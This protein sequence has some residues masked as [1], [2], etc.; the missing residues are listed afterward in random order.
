MTLTD[1]IYSPVSKNE[2]LVTIVQ[3][4]RDMNGAET[5][6]LMLTTVSAP[7]RSENVTSN[8]SAEISADKP[9]T[10]DEKKVLQK[11]L[12]VGKL[13]DTLKG[14][15]KPIRQ[16]YPIL[17]RANNLVSYDSV[18][19]YNVDDLKGA[20]LKI[21]EDKELMRFLNDFIVI[22]KDNISNNPVFLRAFL[23]TILALTSGSVAS[24]K[25]GLRIGAEKNPTSLEEV[26]KYLDTPGL[27]EA[28]LAALDL[29]YDTTQM[30]KAELKELMRFR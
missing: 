2:R 14:D 20:V 25:L 5:Y 4:S 23:G 9:L 27:I 30:T 17:E 11:L 8:M 3:T 28:E 24:N 15:T 16:K 22:T 1:S 13:P 7:R 10:E 18:Y 26:N 12:S 21:S 6:V 19:S 29:E